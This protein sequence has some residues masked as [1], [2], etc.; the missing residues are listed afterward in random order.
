MII[1]IDDEDVVRYWAPIILTFS[2]MIK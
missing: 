1:L 2:L